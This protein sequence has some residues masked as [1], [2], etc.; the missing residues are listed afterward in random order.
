[1]LFNSITSAAALLLLSTLLVTIRADVNYANDGWHMDHVFK[2]VDEQLD[3]IVSVQFSLPSHLI[4]G[5]SPLCTDVQV[6]PNAQSS[7]MHRVV[8]GSNFRAGYSYAGAQSSKCSSVAIQGDK[9][10]YWMPRKVPEYVVLALSSPTLFNDRTL[11]DQQSYLFHS[12]LC[13][14]SI[15]LLLGSQQ[16]CRSCHPVP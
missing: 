6:S 10:N 15:L 1:M 4:E 5:S 11:L 13:Q 2:L 14:H 8:G 12:Y 3:P 9:S 7:H 16:R